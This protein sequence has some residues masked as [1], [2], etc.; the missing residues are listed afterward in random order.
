MCRTTMEILTSVAI[1]TKGTVAEYGLNYSN[2]L[3]KLSK[4]I[5]FYMLPLHDVHNHTSV[6]ASCCLD[7]ATN[8]STT[9]TAVVQKSVT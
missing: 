9:E 6:K 1:V 3:P 4:N 7:S 8:T 5:G 2:S